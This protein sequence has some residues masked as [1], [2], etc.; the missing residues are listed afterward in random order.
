[1]V[2]FQ[3]KDLPERFG[4]RIEDV[5]LGAGFKDSQLRRGFIIR[6]SEVKSKP[7]SYTS[8]K[9]MPDRNYKS[10]TICCILKDM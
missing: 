10:Q 9:I 5:E 4:S 7:C 1:M 8:S 6:V 3:G 2:Q